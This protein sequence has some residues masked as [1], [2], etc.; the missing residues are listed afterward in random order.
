MSYRDDLAA[1]HARIAALERE[2]AQLKA[3]CRRLHEGILELQPDA[4][5]GREA[6]EQRSGVAVREAEQ[7]RRATEKEFEQELRAKMKR[8]QA[9]AEDSVRRRLDRAAK[10]DKSR[11]TRTAGSEGDG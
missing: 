8:W 6:R 5:V 3:E 9:E 7:S 10:A 2:V 1:A 11:E 4:L